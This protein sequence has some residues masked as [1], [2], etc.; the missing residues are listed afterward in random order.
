MAYTDRDTGKPIPEIE[1]VRKSIIDILTTP[2]GSRVMLAEYGSDLWKLVDRVVNRQTI[3]DYRRYTI[4]ALDKW[5]PR[6]SITRIVF[7]MTQLPIG[8][9]SLEL[10]GEYKPTG[11][12]IY[13]DSLELKYRSIE[14]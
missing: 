5:E 7:D 12:A 6:I 3:A 2:M 11:E 1:H 13:F 9:V 4:E 14:P 10:W 8:I